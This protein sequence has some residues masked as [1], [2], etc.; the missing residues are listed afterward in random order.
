[1][2][3]VYSKQVRD[4][5]SRYNNAFLKTPKN[6]FAVRYDP[7]ATRDHYPV[8]VSGWQV[9]LAVEIISQIFMH[10]N[11]DIQHDK[12]SVI[13]HCCAKQSDACVTVW[14]SGSGILETWR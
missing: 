1:M 3:K 4:L 14:N 9:S 7:K 11:G 2:G 10:I 5:S 8:V 6:R 13:I 12:L